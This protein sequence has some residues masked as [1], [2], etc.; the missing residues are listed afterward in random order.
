MATLPES[1]RAVAI[2]KAA[3][4]THVPGLA[5]LAR[6]LIAVAEAEAIAD[7]ASPLAG[8]TTLAFVGDR[9]VQALNYSFRNQNKPTNVLSF[10]S[11]AGGGDVILALETVLREAEEQG[12]TA[13]AHTAH[14]IV[15]GILHL[16][17]YDHLARGEA[18]RMEMLER[19]V[20]GR[21]GIGDPYA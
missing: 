16:M 20:L 17:G 18:R 6:R 13:E 9:T 3:W 14:L 7:G 8:E 19:R 4:R 1:E 11:P 15:H 2:R 5:R 10:P 21:F 12:K